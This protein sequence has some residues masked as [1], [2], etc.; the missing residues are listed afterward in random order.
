MIQFILFKNN[1]IL[2]QE[3]GFH[4]NGKSAKFLENHIYLY[5][6]VYSGISYSINNYLKKEI[7]KISITSFDIAELINVRSYDMTT[8]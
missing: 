4:E 5:A 3:I 8:K 2:S 6:I 7:V 1:C